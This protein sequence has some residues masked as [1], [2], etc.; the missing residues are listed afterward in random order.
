EG[1]NP[2]K[3]NSD[4]TTFPWWKN[5]L[6]SYLIG[7]D[8]ELWDLVELGPEFEGIDNDGKLNALQ[9]KGL[10]PTQKKA[11]AKHHRVKEILSRCISHDEYLKIGDKTSAKSMY[12]SLCS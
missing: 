6:Y 10:T 5:A 4:P 3:F 8:D 12:D 2:P 1:K 11:Y 7:I 9:R